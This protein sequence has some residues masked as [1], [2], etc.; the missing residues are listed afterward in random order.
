M[1]EDYWTG[2]LAGASSLDLATDRVRPAARGNAV[3][4]VDLAL[5]RETIR[6]LDEVGRTYGVTRSTT[7]L[8]V[9]QLV[10]GRYAGTRDVCVG[11]PAERLLVLRTTWTDDPAFA[12]LL[13]RVHATTAEAHAH[14]DTA[15]EPPHDLVRA[16]FGRGAPADLAVAWDDTSGDLSGVVEYDSDLFDRATVRRLAGHYLTL[17]DAALA[18]PGARVSG[19]AHTTPEE[20]ALLASWG[21]GVHADRAASVVHE[22]HARADARPDAVALVFGDETLTYA[23]L[24]ARSDDLARVLMAHGV[25]PESV[26]ALAMERSARLVVAMLAVLVAGGAYLPLDSGHPDARLAF[27]VADSEAGLVLTDRD[28]DLPGDVPVLPVDELSTLERARRAFPSVHRDQRACVFYT[29]GST[30]QPKG[31]AVTHRGIVRLVRDAEYLGVGPADVVAQVANVSFDAATLDVWGALLNGARTVA[32]RKDDALSPESLRARI[33][34]RGITTMFLTTAVFNQCVD[35]DPTMF[36]PMRTIMFGGEEAD[37]RRVAALR[38]AVPGLR[39]VNGYGPTEC[40]TFAAT[41]QVLA[42]ADD[43]VRLPIGGPLADTQLHVLDE[44]G[45][46]TGV[47]VPGELHIGGAG[48]ARGYVGRPGLTA[49]RFVPSPF[50]VGE[51]LYRTGDVAR[52][53]EDGVLEYLSRMDTQVKIR[54]VRIEPEEIASVLATHDDVRTAVVAVRGTGDARRLVAYV[55]AIDARPVD[56]RALREHLAARLPEAMVPAWF[57]ALDELPLTPNGKVDRRALPAPSERDGV[58]AEL[59]VAPRDATEDVLARIWAELLE[60][61]D[62][63]VHDDFF[64]LGGHSLLATQVVARVAARLGADLGIRDLFEAPTVAQLAARVATA[65]R[66]DSYTPG[67]RGRSRAAPAVLRPATPLVPRPAHPGQPA[68]QHPGGPGDRRTA[69]RDRPPARRPGARAAPRVAAHPAGG[70]RP[71]TGDRQGPRTARRGRGPP[72]PARVVPRQRGG[73]AGAGRGG[74]AVRPGS[75]PVA[76]GPAAPARRRAVPAPAHHAPRHLRRLVGRRADRRPR[77]TLRSR[78]RAARATDP[79]HRLF[80]VAARASGG[81]GG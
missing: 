8:A 9:Y 30:G 75:R 67:R 36:A 78:G 54:G 65:R 15:G 58:Q 35:A 59:R 27:M 52:W 19:L 56:P 23:E 79:V 64:T 28:L 29:S 7:L 4:S 73:R 40:T 16:L 34:D 22:F 76:A 41:H 5:E 80:G 1:S 62:V 13:D 57:V 24:R 39:V 21:T 68:L 2:H 17:L 48:L 49:E 55:V 10:L 12:V 69:R 77:R 60:V 66:A 25:G 50:G 11:L 53:R 51:R 31:V 63:S 14:A 42:V 71:A 81:R 70:R 33:A 20:R 74:G 46:E 38:A 43:A 32:I 37:A 47:G 18:D 45:R 3:G 61:T 6:R 44:S 72:A 26:V